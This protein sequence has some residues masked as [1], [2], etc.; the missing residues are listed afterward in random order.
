MA[1][2]AL[3]PGWLLWSLPAMFLLFSCIISLFSNFAVIY[4]LMMPLVPLVAMATGMNSM[5]LFAGMCLGS[6]ATGLSPFSTGG[7]CQ[8]SGCDDPDK[9]ARLT[10]RLFALAAA[11][12]VILAVIISTGILNFLPDPMAL[13]PMN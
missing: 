1:D 6:C 11:N 5:V 4:P 8:L 9:V 3:L 12:A 7:A 2:G 10:P 13:Y